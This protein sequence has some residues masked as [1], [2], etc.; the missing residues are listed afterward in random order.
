MYWPTTFKNYVNLWK[1][2]KNNDNLQVCTPVY[3]QSHQI[4]SMSRDF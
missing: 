3:K 1:Y 4:H 2:V